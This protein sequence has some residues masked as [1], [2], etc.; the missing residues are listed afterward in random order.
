MKLSANILYSYM[1]V[2]KK[3][4]SLPVIFFLSCNN[5]LVGLLSL[6]RPW[7]WVC[8]VWAGRGSSLQLTLMTSGT[9]ATVAMTTG[10]S[11]WSPL[12]ST[13]AQWE[14]SYYSC[15][16]QCARLRWALL[17]V[18]LPLKQFISGSHYIL[19]THIAIW[20]KILL[21]VSQQIVHLWK[22]LKTA[23]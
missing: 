5:N 17:M 7:V 15:W 3:C 19:K 8:L 21:Y 22:N 4:K 23:V 10:S 18:C 9:L 14:T 6:F 16:V 13:A 2:I 11:P 1:S 20:W 12:S